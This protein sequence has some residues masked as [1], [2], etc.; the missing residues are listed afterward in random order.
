MGRCS[1]RVGKK[2]LE[3]MKCEHKQEKI[4]RCDLGLR[5]AF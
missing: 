4:H 2:H 5:D 1:A 3:K